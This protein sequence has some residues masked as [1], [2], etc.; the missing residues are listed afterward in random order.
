VLLGSAVSSQA[1]VIDF[2]TGSLLL[3]SLGQTG[4]LE[5]FDF[6]LSSAG[7]AIVLVPV[8]AGSCTPPCISD[9]TTTLGALNDAD[10]TIAPSSGRSFSLLAF[11]TAGTFT[12]SLRNITSMEVIGNVFGGGQVTETFAVNPNIFQTFSLLPGFTHLASAE[13]VGLT[14]VGVRSP[15][16]QLDNIVVNVP[17]PATLAL[18]GLGLAGLAA[19]RRRKQ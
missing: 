14:P 16:F 3:S 8:T 2:E 12:V 18:L 6:T 13:F 15:E 7:S 17:E 5:G 11:D 19:S 10:V 4:S 1:S 9:A